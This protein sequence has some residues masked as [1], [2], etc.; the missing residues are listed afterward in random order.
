MSIRI[1]NTSRI[2]YTSFM[3]NN[4]CKFCKSSKVKRNGTT[5]S[6]AKRWRCLVCKKSWSVVKSTTIPK[7]NHEEMFIKWIQGDSMSRIASDYN[8]SHKQVR[9]I[10]LERLSQDIPVHESDY[11]NVKYIM[12]DGKYIFGRKYTMLNIMDA[13]TRKP[14]ATRIGSGENRRS[15]L[16][17]LKLLKRQGLEPIA[18]TLDGRTGAPQFFAEV[19]PNIKTQRC[20]FHIDMQVRAWCRRPP[21]YALGK[22]LSLFLNGLTYMKSDDEEKF[23]AGFEDIKKAHK[24]SILEYREHKEYGIYRDMVRAVT[25][26][27][28]ALP[29]MFHCLY[30]QKI[31]RTTSPLEGFHKQVD[32]AVN[33]DHNGMTEEH[34]FKFLEWFV[35]YK[36][37]TN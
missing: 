23:R 36:N 3:S 26:I 8:Y 10:I 16:P 27:Q 21:R 9:R 7:R 17:W 31:A 37:H 28:N 33:F 32:R 15:I 4:R 18:V 13:K 22:T 35:Y 2:L 24:S 20:L 6:G 5:K 14:I 30:D 1:Q 29:N 12:F 25:L 34:C 11:K 19:W